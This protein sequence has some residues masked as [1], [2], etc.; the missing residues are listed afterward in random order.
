MSDIQMDTSIDPSSPGISDSISSS[1]TLPDSTFCSEASP[2]RA[3]VLDHVLV[4]LPPFLHLACQL[5]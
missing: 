1:C 5:S 3:M 2:L 4:P